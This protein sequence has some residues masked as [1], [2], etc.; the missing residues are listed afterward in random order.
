MSDCAADAILEV[1]IIEKQHIKADKGGKVNS[2]FFL[3]VS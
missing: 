1:K 2:V 3:P